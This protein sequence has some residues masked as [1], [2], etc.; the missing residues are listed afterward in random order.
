MAHKQVFQTNLIH[1]SCITLHSSSK[2]TQLFWTH[3]SRWQVIPLS[4]S[5]MYRRKW[6]WSLTLDTSSWPK[7]SGSR[8]ESPNHRWKRPWMW[9]VCFSFPSIAKFFLLFYINIQRS[10]TQVLSKSIRGQGRQV[11]G[12]IFI[13]MSGVHHLAFLLTLLLQ[14]KCMRMSKVLSWGS[15][16]EKV[17]LKLYME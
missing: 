2:E 17:M 12:Y 7:I 3:F 15:G 9:F 16:F 4:Y 14:A 10:G 1:V 6:N 13:L 11:E 8:R 5:T